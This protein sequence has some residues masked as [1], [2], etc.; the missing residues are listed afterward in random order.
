MNKAFHVPS[1]DKVTVGGISAEQ[2]PRVP[3]SA[4]PSFD[5]FNVNSP[6]SVGHQPTKA[7]MPPT[8]TSWPPEK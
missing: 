4:T 6:T 5:A 3:A 2:M 8:G 1:L 7:D